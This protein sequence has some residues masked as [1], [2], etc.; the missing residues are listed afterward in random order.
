MTSH[1]NT[2]TGK[3]WITDTTFIHYDHEHIQNCHMDRSPVDRYYFKGI[4]YWYFF[5]MLV[6]YKI[7]LNKHSSSDYKPPP[8]WSWNNLLKSPAWFSFEKYSYRRSK[9][10]VVFT[11]S[12]LQSPVPWNTSEFLFIMMEIQGCLLHISMTSIPGLWKHKLA[13][14]DNRVTY[15]LQF[16]YVA[17]KIWP[18]QA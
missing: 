6:S 7:L 1:S 8:H 5:F 3:P 13:Q 17:G 12:A 16:I 11:A 10:A 2:W 4:T 15:S 18:H 9:L 14:L